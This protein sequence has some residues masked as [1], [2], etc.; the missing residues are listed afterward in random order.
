MVGEDRGRAHSSA[1][2]G[3][4]R[5]ER[6]PKPDD[7]YNHANRRYCHRYQRSQ[8]CFPDCRLIHG[9][10]TAEEVEQEAAVHSF[11][12]RAG[13]GG[14]SA[15]GA[16]A[17]GASAGGASAGGGSA[18]RQ[19]SRPPRGGGVNWDI[20]DRPTSVQMG[21]GI[22]ALI[23][24][25]PPPGLFTAAVL[26]IRAFLCA[27]LSVC[28]I[29]QHPE[30]ALTGYANGRVYQ[31][32]PSMHRDDFNSKWPSSEFLQTLM[33][34]RLFG[35]G[36]ECGL[37]AMGDA[38][39]ALSQISGLRPGVADTRG[40]DWKLGKVRGFVSSTPE[41]HIATGCPHIFFNANRLLK[42]YGDAAYKKSHLLSFLF[43]VVSWLSEG[44]D[45]HVHCIPLLFPPGGLIIFITDAQ[46]TA[47]RVVVGELKTIRGGPLQLKNRAGRPQPKKDPRGPA[48]TEKRF[49]SPDPN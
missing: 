11:R 28:F 19:S 16:S 49:E 29:I 4:G 18:R 17:G 10:P 2:G 44:R 42:N 43:Q 46:C 36:I 24:D 34:A 47:P 30:A 13:G 37:Q 9:W 6:V 1:P 21:D 38:A 27:A 22:R 15:G 12:S 39:A 3:F 25:K 32:K 8:E 26:G 14:G 31:L 40:D 35:G 5:W 7:P 23:L 48:R 41:E 20:I 45:V 33:G